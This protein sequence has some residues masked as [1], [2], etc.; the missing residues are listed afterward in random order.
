MS[1][2][3]SM[4]R[5]DALRVLAALGTSLAAP[6]L[7]QADECAAWI[8]QDLEFEAIKKLG[9]EFMASRSE[10]ER[11]SEIASLLEK[12]VSEDAAFAEIQRRIRE[13]FA[14]D[15]IVKLSDWFVSVTEGC[16]FAVL[17]NCER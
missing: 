7:S 15:R 10:G 14:A 6:M 16:I 17:A 13:D 3:R 8:A 4:N 9:R 2:E 1:R 12:A 5:R 11:V